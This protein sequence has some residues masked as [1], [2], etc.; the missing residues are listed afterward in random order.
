MTRYILILTIF[1]MFACGKTKNSRSETNRSNKELDKEISD[2]VTIKK[3]VGNDN[4]YLNHSLVDF[5]Y[6]CN[7]ELLIISESNQKSECLSMWDTSCVFVNIDLYKQR[8]K[9]WE[10]FKKYA[11]NDSKNTVVK[12]DPS[13]NLVITHF[14][15]PSGFSKQNRVEFYDFSDGD[16][17]LK[18]IDLTVDTKINS[19]QGI[20][21]DTWQYLVDFETKKIKLDYSELRMS[22]DID[23]EPDL[24]S[25]DTTIYKEFIDDINVKL[26]EPYEIDSL[27]KGVHEIRY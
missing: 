2:S 10:L 25:S 5:N 15:K 1:S 4:V 17:Y 6:D 24:S 18:K 11:I 9:E 23:G 12:I 27:L 19:G 8:D 14:S 7:V 3:L 22:Y 26:G 13:W 20:E 16:F 21:K